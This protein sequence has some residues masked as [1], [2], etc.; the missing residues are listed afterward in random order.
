MSPLEPQSAP[1]RLIIN[2]FAGPG[3]R[4]HHGT[5]LA[6]AAKALIPGLTV[7]YTDG[8]QHATKLAQNAALEGVCRVYAAGGD[9]TVNEVLQGLVGTDTSLCPLPLGTANVACHELGLPVSSP[10]AALKVALKRPDQLA[11]V[12]RVEGDNYRH[13]FLLMTGI[14]ID[15]AVIADIH[16]PTKRK[17]GIGAYFL[18]GVLT[19]LRYRF[20]PIQVR[21][22]DDPTP[23][24]ASSVII[25]NGVNYAAGVT[26]VPDA[27]LT[28]PDLCLL[29]FAGTD[30]FPYLRYI[31]G[32][33]VGRH[34][35]MRGVSVRRGQRFTVSSQS[36]MRG[37]TDGELTG[38]LPLTISACPEAI[39]LPL[40]NLSHLNPSI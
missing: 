22:D 4:R 17:L 30:P 39:R 26:L 6:T 33:M 35:T 12:G 9:G 32:L 13:Y 8:P 37:H 29:G 18:Q 40:S 1:P 14:G 36:P 10:L 20:L 34:T 19:S 15:S 16:G 27:G 31:A 11:T 23:I 7:C 24:V 2:P 28:R 5:D 21:V 25:A 38:P 3:H